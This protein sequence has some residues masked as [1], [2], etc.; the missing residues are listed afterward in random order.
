[1]DAGFPS[2]HA[3]AKISITFITSGRNRPEVIAIYV[4]SSYRIGATPFGEVVP[5][6]RDARWGIHGLHQIFSRAWDLG[7]PN[8]LAIVEQ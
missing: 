7:C 3:S 2:D 8:L 1:V 5:L 6:R 4:C